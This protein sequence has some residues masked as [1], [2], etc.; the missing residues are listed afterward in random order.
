MLYL[1]R[2][3]GIFTE[4]SG[5][6]FR[7]ILMLRPLL[8]LA[9]LA[10]ACA[11]PTPANSPL[12]PAGPPAPAS[13]PRPTPLDLS[14]GVEPDGSPA[15]ERQTSDALPVPP[16]YPG[17]DA[18]KAERRQWLN[19]MQAYRAQYGRTPESSKMMEIAR[20]HWRGKRR[21][22]GGTVAT[23]AAG[24]P[25]PAH[26]LID[27]NLVL[28]PRPT[29]KIVYGAAFNDAAGNPQPLGS[30]PIVAH[31]PVTIVGISCTA[32]LRA[33][34]GTG[35]CSRV[36]VLTN[37]LGRLGTCMRVRSDA[38]TTAELAAIK[39]SWMATSRSNRL[40][41]PKLQL[42]LSKDP[43]RFYSVTFNVTQLV[44]ESRAAG[45]D[46]HHLGGCDPVVVPTG[47]MV[48][49]TQKRQLIYGFDGKR[50]FGNVVPRKRAKLTAIS[51]YDLKRASNGRWGS[52]H[53]N[54]EWSPMYHLWHDEAQKKRIVAQ[55][56][57]ARTA[58]PLR[59][60]AVEV[61]RAL[62]DLKFER[63]AEAK[64]SMDR[65]RAMRA[66][67]YG[68]DPRLAIDDTITAFD[69]IVLQGKWL[70]RDPCLTQPPKS[71]P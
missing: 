34:A 14:L 11:S 38:A 30:T 42:S 15:N 49:N 22:A 62:I 46:G 9:L 55:Q 4:S 31:S 6:H 10:A 59:K 56:Q 40:M 7:S 29:H 71:K 48:P 64:A 67:G 19:S 17:I 5:V 52:W 23:N 65:V 54:V 21:A 28:K 27:G 26:L 16:A 51:F 39:R 61:N 70:L 58:S 24:S 13:P 45:C 60:I 3:A 25:P 37:S 66:Q 12:D 18:N 1:L 44:P 68:A 53:M 41:P 33:G 32:D 50:F 43:T 8:P 69:E 2:I 35:Q 57:L 20:K 47:R 63:V 36:N